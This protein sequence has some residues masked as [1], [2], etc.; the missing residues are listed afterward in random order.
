MALA[1]DLIQS[2]WEMIPVRIRGVLE[3]LSQS[4]ATCTLHVSQIWLGTQTQSQ[5]QTPSI[6]DQ[7][8][9]I[10]WTVREE[11]GVRF[12]DMRQ[13]SLP[14]IEKKARS[15]ELSR[16]AMTIVPDEVERVRR[17]MSMTYSYQGLR[18]TS[19][20]KIVRLIGFMRNYGHE[21]LNSWTS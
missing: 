17:I 15:C 19:H 21:Q 20:L 3:N 5:Y 12:K 8:C 2:R 10:P 13:G 6:P 9:F 1:I 14:L 11:S 4:G 18:D 16:H 7:D